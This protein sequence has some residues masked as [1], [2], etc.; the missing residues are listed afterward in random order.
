MTKDLAG[1]LWKHG[2]DQALQNE[3]LQA[4]ICFCPRINRGKRS[5]KSCAEVRHL[6]EQIGLR[7]FCFYRTIRR[8][9]GIRKAAVER[10]IRSL[11]T[12]QFFRD[13]QRLDRVSGFSHVENDIRN[14]FDR[15]ALVSLTRN[16]M[17][18]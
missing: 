9:Q 2:L 12:R 5:S 8:P 3:L 13:R 18:Q 14:R 11:E 1:I 6:T 17:P 15:H 16:A 4:L 7:G 10:L